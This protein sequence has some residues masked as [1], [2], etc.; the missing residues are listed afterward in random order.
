MTEPADCVFQ[1]HL[2]HFN[3]VPRKVW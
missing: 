2:C 1:N 3:G